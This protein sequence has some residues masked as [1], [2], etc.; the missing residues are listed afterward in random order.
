MKFCLEKTTD[1]EAQINLFNKT[2]NIKFSSEQWQQKHMNNPY[3][4][5]SESVCLYDENELIGFNLFMPQEYMINGQKHVLIQSC[6]SV[7]DTEWRGHGLLQEI[8]KQAEELLSS[9]YDVIYGVPNDKSIRTFEKLGYKKKTDLDI[10]VKKTKNLRFIKEGISRVLKL[11]PDN[12]AEA[13][14]ARLDAACE[15]CGVIISDRFCLDTCSNLCEGITVNRDET[16]YRWKVDTNSSNDF[17]YLFVEEHG[18][19]KAACVIS[20]RAGSWLSGIDIK[21]IIIGKD[22]EDALKLI[23]KAIGKAVSLARVV[24]NHGGEAEKMLMRAG[25]MIHKE[26]A[27][28]LVY[29]VISENKET[30]QLMQT[31]PWE[32]AEIEADTIFN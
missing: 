7:I 11:K 24:V 19:I 20:L 21:D 18:V 15:S 30:E 4:G 17:R 5:T 32:F 13:M 9:E 14:F 2:F 1:N 26:K 16:F 25:F 22:G 23:L 29:K 28:S 6:E 27:S 12:S 31:E 3:K 8:L 10:V